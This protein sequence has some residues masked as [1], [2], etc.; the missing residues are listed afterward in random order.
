MPIGYDMEAIKN[1]TK[2]KLGAA[3]EEQKLKNKGATDAATI[4]DTGATTRNTAELNAKQGYYD[5][6]AAVNNANATGTTLENTLKQ[7]TMGGVVDATNSASARDT[8]K[9]SLEQVT[10]QTGAMQKGFDVN[11]SGNK[12]GVSDKVIAA[13]SNKMDAENEAAVKATTDPSVIT[14]K[15]PTPIT[16]ELDKANPVGKGHL[17]YKKPGAWK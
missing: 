7:K 15:R 11:L 16:D 2:I 10:A 9:N 8:F 1:A 4:T 5:S 13:H 14:I 12:A 17:R 6:H 3:L